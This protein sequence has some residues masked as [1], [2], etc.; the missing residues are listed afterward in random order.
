M[1]LKDTL[2]LIKA[3]YTREE[4]K[5]FETEQEEPEAKETDSGVIK[6]LGL[7]ADQINALQA[8]YTKG[9]QTEPETKDDIN[10]ILAKLQGS[11]EEKGD[12]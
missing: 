8:A 1:K 2:A 6:A 4:I 3:G 11:N 9:S 7:M 10:M 12:N 5:A